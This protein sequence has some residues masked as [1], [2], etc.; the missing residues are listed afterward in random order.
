MRRNM[1][2]SLSPDHERDIGRLRRCP[3]P[4]SRSCSATTPD[5]PYTVGAGDRLRFIVFGQDSL[6]NSYS[7][8][9]SGQI[10]MPLIGLVPVT[11]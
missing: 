11:A 1:A 9:A 10:S 2:S 7:V 6:S 8:D 4:T 3:A 5:E